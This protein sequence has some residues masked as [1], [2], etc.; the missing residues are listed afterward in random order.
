[1]GIIPPQQPLGQGQQLC[2]VLIP[3]KLP[4]KGNGLVTF[5]HISNLDLGNVTIRH[6]YVIFYQ[7]PT[8]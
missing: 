1:M 5:F 8:W 2:E 3:S 6:D 7:D 4:V